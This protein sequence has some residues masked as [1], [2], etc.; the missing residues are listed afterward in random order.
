MN[1]QT[2]SWTAAPSRRWLEYKSQRARA[3]QVTGCFRGTAVHQGPEG[4][5]EGLSG[6]RPS[7]MWGDRAT[8][9]VPRNLVSC[10][11]ASGGAKLSAT[12]GLLSFRMSVS[13]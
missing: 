3:A 10:A 5:E 4:C 8:S 9:P 2:G 1:I 12:W 7:G 11:L 6:N 13:L